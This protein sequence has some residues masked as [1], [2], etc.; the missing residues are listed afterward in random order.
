LIGVVIEIPESPGLRA[1][2]VSYK[3]MNGLGDEEAPSN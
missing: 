3:M 1:Q 2:L